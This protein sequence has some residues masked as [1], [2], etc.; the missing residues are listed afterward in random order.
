MFK[1]AQSRQA[2]PC[3]RFPLRLFHE[4][5]RLRSATLGSHSQQKQSPERARTARSFRLL[6]MY[7]FLLSCSWWQTSS[8]LHFCLWRPHPSLVLQPNLP[9]MTRRPRRIVA[10][11]HPTKR[12]GI[13]CHLLSNASLACGAGL[14]R[15]GLRC[16]IEGKLDVLARNREIFAQKAPACPPSISPHS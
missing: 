5:S 1:Y 4:I 16:A 2:K 12:R 8:R 9:M 6:R 14:A 10:L 15:P 11:S 7:G 13:I 3:I